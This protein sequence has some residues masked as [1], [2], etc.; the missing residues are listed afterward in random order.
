MKLLAMLSAFLP[1]AVS[2]VWLQFLPDRVPVH[3]GFAGNIDRWGS[4]WEHLIAAGAALALA[5]LLSLTGLLLR[6]KAGNDEKK[7]AYAESNCRILRVTVIGVSLLS[8]ALQVFFLLSAGRAAGGAEGAP[9]P[10]MKLAA[11][12]LGL[13]MIVLGNLMPKARRNSALGF[14]CSWTQYNDAAWQ[15]SNRFAGGAMIAAGAV[16]VLA[17]LPVPESW[18]VPVLLG[19][20]LLAGLVSTV[21]ARRVYLEEKGKE[22]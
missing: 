18:A 8:T 14:R 15:R 9:A 16:G 7:L 1:L 19:A 5:A 4:K 22:V 12:G 13:L 10:M 2:G 21:Y 11:I 6:R 17:A 20:I 3:Y